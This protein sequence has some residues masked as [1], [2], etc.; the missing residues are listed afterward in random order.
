MTGRV[1]IFDSINTDFVTYVDAFAAPAAAALSTT[2]RGA[3]TSMP[4]ADE[5]DRILCGNLKLK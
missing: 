1:L 3:R 2:V 5:I 4:T